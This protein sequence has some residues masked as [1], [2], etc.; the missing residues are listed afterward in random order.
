MKL[1][2]PLSMAIDILP[3]LRIRESEFIGHE[4]HDRSVFVVEFFH[5]EG[6]PAAVETPYWK[7]GGDFAEEGSR[8]FRERVEVDVVDA[9]PEEVE[10]ALLYQSVCIVRVGI[11]RVVRLRRRRQG[12]S[13]P[14][15][16]GYRAV[17]SP[18]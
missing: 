5:F 11:R 15:R 3:S 10:C 17:E 6:P 14:A 2:V 8:V 13:L 12:C 9:A 1:R 16:A 7:D 18:Y 4:A